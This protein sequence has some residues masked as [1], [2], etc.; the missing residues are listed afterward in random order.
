MAA[1]AVAALAVPVWPGTASADVIFDQADAEELAGILA[2]AYEAQRVCYGWVVD[3]NNVGIQESSAGSNFGVGPA[4]DE[5]P[6][7]QSCETTVEFQAD[8]TWTSE[9]SEAEDSASYQVVSNPSGPTT[10]D[11][12]S[13]QLISVDSLKGDNVDVDVF[14]AVSAL[15]LL[16]ADAGVAEPLEASPAPESAVAAANGAPTNSPGSDFWRRA[17][18]AMLWA[19][20]LILAAVVFAVWALRSSR[21]AARAARAPREQAPNF[22]P[23]DWSDGPGGTV[24][25]WDP[26]AG[27]SGTPSGDAPGTGRSTG[28]AV[29]PSRQ[30]DAPD[31][32]QGPGGD[33]G[34]ED[35]R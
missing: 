23:P 24:P 16:A 11:L 26:S 14:K 7:A 18:G 2:E 4:L 27:P 35:R 15:P 17:G 9:S 20:A 31:P 21:P 6:E 30:R 19:G 8:V 12:D 5:V 25:V 3:V 28:P 13:L 29:P 1:L 34:P 10:S 33:G 22:L 32:G